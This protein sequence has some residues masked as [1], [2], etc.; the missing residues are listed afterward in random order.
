MSCSGPDYESQSHY[1]AVLQRV[2][3]GERSGPMM[4]ERASVLVHATSFSEALL[5][6]RDWCVRESR[7]YSAGAPPDVQMARWITHRI[8]SIDVVRLPEDGGVQMIRADWSTPSECTV[9]FEHDEPPSIDDVPNT[10]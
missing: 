3:V 4:A 10:I 7:P 5:I 2:C 1:L 6:V 9:C 8:E